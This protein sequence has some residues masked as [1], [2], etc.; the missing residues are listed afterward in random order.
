M[1]WRWKVLRL[2][3]NNILN[4]KVGNVHVHEEQDQKPGTKIKSW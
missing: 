2:C 1:I 4:L 3:I